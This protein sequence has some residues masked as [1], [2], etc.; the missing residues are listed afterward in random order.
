VATS[1]HHRGRK[2]SQTRPSTKKL[3]QKI[4]LSMRLF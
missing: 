3:A 2:R 1:A 4:F